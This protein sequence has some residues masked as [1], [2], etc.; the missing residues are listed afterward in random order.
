MCL[1][2]QQHGSGNFIPRSFYRDLIKNVYRSS[3]AVLF[4]LCKN[5]I[6]FEISRH[7]FNV[8]SNINFHEYEF[9]CSTPFK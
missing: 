9:K 5:I 3:S 8:F 1:F 7:V 4:I 2:S 6:N